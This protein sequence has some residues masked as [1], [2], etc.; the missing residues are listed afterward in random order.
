MLTMTM[1]SSA[2]YALDRECA[3]HGAAVGEP[4]QAYQTCTAVVVGVCAAR[5]NQ[6]P[7]ILRHS[8]QQTEKRNAPRS[9][10]RQGERSKRIGVASVT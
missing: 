2:V 8:V 10:G 7:V 4:C 6:K 3:I 5:L 1:P 9:L